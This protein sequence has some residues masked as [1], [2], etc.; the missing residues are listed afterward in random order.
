MTSAVTYNKSQERLLHVIRGPHISEKGAG[1][2]DKHKQ[3]V[4]KVDSNA[5]KPEI[6]QAVEMLFDVKVNAVTVCNVR[7]KARRFKQMLG[8]R[9]GW[10]KAYVSL[11]EGYDIDFTGN[12]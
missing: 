5:N 12:K 1:L 6:K 11:K 2:G 7:G 9:K 8:Q 10:K 4:F 3:F